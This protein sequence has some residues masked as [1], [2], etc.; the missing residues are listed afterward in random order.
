MQGGLSFAKIW[1]E[2]YPSMSFSGVRKIC[3]ELKREGERACHRRNGTGAKR[4]TSRRDDRAMARDAVSDDSPSAKTIALMHQARTGKKICARTV[5][6]RMREV[7]LRRCLKCRK[8]YINDD[9]RERRLTWARKHISWSIEDWMRVL[10]SDESPFT[11][12]YKAQQWIWRTPSEKYDHRCLKGTVKS[13][14]F[15]KKLMVW[16]C[17][18]GTKVGEL[19]RIDGIM[20]AKKYHS[21][22]QRHMFPSAQ[23]CSKMTNNGHLCT[24]MIQ[25][26]Q[27]RSSLDIWRTKVLL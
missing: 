18:A 17:F 25:S 27:R 21:I 22:L 1:K 11:I 7:N 14:K 12:R 24:I 19:V 10:W 20:D 5:K 13:T 16:G 23:G 3:R 15:Q 8:P 9:H 26:I 6:S 2:H 4:K